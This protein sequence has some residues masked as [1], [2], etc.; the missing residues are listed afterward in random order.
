MPRSVLSEVSYDLPVRA[1][2]GPAELT[3][4]D[5]YG[6]PRL[7][8]IDHGRRRSTEPTRALHPVTALTAM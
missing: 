6:Y 5:G 8:G 2:P 1:P 4:I 7:P 3:F